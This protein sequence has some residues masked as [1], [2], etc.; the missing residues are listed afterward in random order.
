MGFADLAYIGGWYTL[1]I[2]FVAGLTVLAWFFGALP[3]IGKWIRASVGVIVLLG[4]AFLAGM[5]IMFRHN[6]ADRDANREKIKE[7]QKQQPK[8]GWPF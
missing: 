4:G 5:T 1:I 8:S 3:V 2:A 7:L 6:K